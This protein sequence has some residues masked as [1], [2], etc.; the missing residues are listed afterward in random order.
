MTP[1]P[2]TI[3]SLL[4]FCVFLSGTAGGC[5]VP[6]LIRAAGGT[7]VVMVLPALF[8]GAPLVLLVR[9]FLGPNCCWAKATS[10]LCGALGSGTIAGCVASGWWIIPI[11]GLDA[12]AKLA[13][14]L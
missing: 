6:S 13:A 11:I 8:L 1:A 4:L 2:R 5:A 10:L 14:L 3:R 12:S 9:F 7:T